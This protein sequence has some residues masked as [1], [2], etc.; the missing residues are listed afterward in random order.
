MR[1]PS[2]SMSHDSWGARS[3]EQLGVES[4]PN[5][6]FARRWGFN[7][8]TAIVARLVR[9]FLTRF[10]SR[11]RM[12][13]GS[14][15]GIWRGRRQTECVPG[16]SGP[17]APPRMGDTGRNARSRGLVR[18]RSVT[19]S[20][21]LRGTSRRRRVPASGPESNSAVILTVP[22][23]CDW[24]TRTEAV[25]K[26]PHAKPEWAVARMSLSTVR[27]LVWAP[28]TSWRAGE[29]GEPR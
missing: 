9:I 11:S 8:E 25:Q 2:P 21:Q 22:G 13:C 10:K 27:R 24:G 3:L 29:A 20:D 7:H 28:R 26:V 12:E 18:H 6:R 5:P 15:F 17:C 16:R 23:G 4:S 14:E 1:R 19:D